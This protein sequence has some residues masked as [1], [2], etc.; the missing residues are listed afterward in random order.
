LAFDHNAHPVADFLDLI[1]E[2]GRE[3]DL[4]SKEANQVMDVGGMTVTPG[5]IDSHC[6]PVLG[7]FTPRQK[8]LDFTT[9]YNRWAERLVDILPQDKY[10][11]TDGFLGATLLQSRRHLSLMSHED[12]R[13]KQEER[14]TTYFSV[15]STL[16]LDTVTRQQFSNIPTFGF[17]EK[18]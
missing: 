6:H 15:K 18:S 17:G 1:Q 4:D 13:A 10:V 9:T 3:K 11:L 5:L 14:F 8:M 2:V 12:V 7:D 16:G